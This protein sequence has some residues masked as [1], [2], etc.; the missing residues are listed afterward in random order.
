MSNSS[1]KKTKKAKRPLWLR[2][3]RW[4]LFTV[5]GLILFLG[6]IWAGLQTRW[7][8]NSLVNLVSSV[9]A[10]T[11]DY[12]VTLRGLDGLLPFSITVDQVT[13]S[14]AKGP[15]LEG[16]KFDFSMKARDLLAGSVQVEWLRMKQLSLSRLPEPAKPD[17]KKEKPPTESGKPL[18]PHI[19]V[20]EIQLKRIELGK[21]VAGKSMAFSLQSRVKTAGSR[22]NAEASLT[23]LNHGDDAFHLRVAYDMAR[24][25]VAAD[26]DYHESKGGLVAGLTGLKDLRDIKLILK[27]D[28]PLS[29]VK[30]RLNL[31]MGGYG[32]AELRFRYGVGLD[33]AMDLQMD[34]Q[35]KAKSRI[36]PSQV[37]QAM[38]SLSLDLTCRA[39][40]SP[41]NVLDLKRF[42]IKNGANSISLEGNADIKKER[43][44]VRGLISGV[45]IAPFLRGTGVSVEDLGP[46]RIT[47][48][49]PFMQPNVTVV[50]MVGSLMAQGASL[51]DMT[52]ETRA[53]FEQ[54]FSGL[55][56]IVVRLK[57]REVRI[58]QAPDLRGPLKV[59]VQAQ[60]PN[61]TVWR[62][63]DLHMAMPGMSVRLEDADVDAAL[64]RFSADFQL[65]VDRIA[66]LL[67]SQAPPIDGQLEIRG[68]AEGNG[69]SP[70]KAN[71]DMAVSRLSGL[72]PEASGLIGPKLTL[73]ARAAMMD[74]IV[75]LEGVH[76]KGGHIQLNADGWLNLSKSAFDVAYDM[77][78]NL[79][80]NP[81]S[82]EENLPVGDVA[83]RGK[84]SGD[85]QDFSAQVNLSSQNL[86]LKTLDVKGLKVQL[87]AK[88]LPQKPAGSIRVKGAV[89]DQPLK[90]DTD[91]AWSGKALS[92]RKG[93]AHL[94]G[95][96][97]RASLSLTPGPN[98]FSGTV[99]GKVTSMD[100]LQDLAGVDVRGTGR[101]R[102]EAGEPGEKEVRQAPITLDANF[103]DLRY[104]G[105]GA[106]TF[107]ARARVDDMK[108]VRGLASLKATDMP[109][110][111]SRIETFKLGATGALAGAEVTLETKGMSKTVTEAPFFLTTKI[112]VKRADLWL[113]RLDALKAG[114]EDLKITLRKPATV[115]LGDGRIAL[116]NL[117]LKTD[118]GQLQVM[119]KLERENVE[120]SARI[121]DLPLSLLEPF[122]GQDLNGRAEVSL[123][124]SGPLADPG[125][126]V[127][128]HIREYKIMGQDG[129][130]PLLMNVKL[131]SRRDGDRL[132]ADLEL[133]GLGKTPFTAN[134][135]IPAHISL[136]P[137]AF[138][139]NKT[140]KLEGKL[141]GKFNLA[142]LQTLPAMTDQSLRGRVDVDMGVEGSLEK[143]D[144]NGGVTVSDGRYENVEQGVLLDRIQGHLSA[145][146]RVLKLTD[147][148]ATD[149]GSGT[150]ALRGR[151]EVDPP[152]QTEIA[153]TMKQATLLKKE[154]LTVTA[155]GNLDV[156]GNKDRMD[157]TGEINLNRTEITIPKRFPPDVTVIPVSTIN[158]PSAAS[159][160]KPKPGEGGNMIQMDLGVNISDKFFV[161]GRGLD[162]EFK[163]RLKVQG[164]ANSPVVRGT[165]NVVRGTFQC[166]SRTFNITSGQIAFDGAT[167]PV[168]YLNISTR[169]NA[170]EIT[171]R[172]DVS[173][174]ADA[175]TLKLSSQP[176]LPQDEIMAQILFG[177]SV[178]K[179]NTF[180]ALQLAYSVNELAG[181]YG[182][183]VIGKTRN[184][185]GLDRLGFSGGD[186]DGKS[187]S[188]NGSGPSVT[189]G[190]YVTDRV[191]VGVEQDLTNA[192]Q[193][194]V[195]EVNV[196]PNFTVESKAGTK[197]GAGLG[198]NWNY[199]Y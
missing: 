154:T 61:F 151:T 83:I 64:G 190:N 73:S 124:L 18:L 126:N 24:E 169:V 87:E 56:N 166:L 79:T 180:Q 88:G 195:V 31:N 152:F 139:V 76:L 43:M 119:A 39:V 168:P 82:A 49:G 12:R 102:I 116:D 157:L 34:G 41:Q 2:L 66:A 50:A 165:L 192:K 53:R 153:L 143:W 5:V 188:D 11:D 108:T 78:L 90:V 60:S 44:D 32:K 162:A 105:Y 68:H 170:G 59:D 21:A 193:D 71:L 42:M 62:V 8:K 128:V 63:K 36:V 19:M 163:G 94:P 101:F 27:A 97:L 184:L 72:P 106:S 37:V 177:Q 173:G 57:T 109:F 52:L 123:E 199:D 134:G 136:K 132:L 26:L 80:G 118:K 14:D 113:F 48:K 95:I 160:E 146:G 1:Q 58:P 197:S 145:E 158:D 121:T 115:T 16:E 107:E 176:P 54:G 74:Q 183:D 129:T 93:R 167:P 30:G 92:I 114:Y 3:F 137:F 89:M 194:V 22:V 144:L 130:P 77:S 140:G 10:N 125:M 133:S 150:I 103:K 46:V 198:F 147:L 149:G 141:Q 181:G 196:T 110:G 45:N 86:Q 35:I 117:E 13:I 33:G 179:L 104:Q 67:P 120:A 111:N 17:S 69:K 174:P 185:L 186:G 178:A 159:P 7:A 172:V 189:L 191:Y 29:G 23:D 15:W 98:H 28:G 91:F 9:T 51:K 4:T 70:V 182:P 81:L 20:Q 75:T 161:R 148:T 47:A 40:L 171:A 127:A 131:H 155:G 156:K 122:V 175:F 187:N 55:K 6:L 99:E 85:F 84:I 38:D 164:S 138:D 135:S 65:H 100:I 25:H 142:I 96:D 112:F